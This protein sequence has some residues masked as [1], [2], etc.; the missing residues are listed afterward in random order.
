MEGE[1]E[2]QELQVALLASAQPLLKPMARALVPVL[3]VETAEVVV[4]EVLQKLTSI[5]QR[6]GQPSALHPVLAQ[7]LGQALERVTRLD[8]S[9]YGLARYTYM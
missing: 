5:A 1:E 6:M 2:K 3:A 7:A 8:D 4:V 9:I